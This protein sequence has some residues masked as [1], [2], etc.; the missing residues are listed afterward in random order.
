MGL[1]DMLLQKFGNNHG[2]NNAINQFGNNLQSQGI[3]DP[4]AYTRQLLNS[5]MMSQE[6]F[7]QFASIANM[8]TGRK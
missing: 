2:I 6:Q 3:N 8:L 1:M 5:G 4:E 7:S